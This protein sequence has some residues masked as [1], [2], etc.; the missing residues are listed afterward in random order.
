MRACDTVLGC[1]RYMFVLGHALH[2]LAA[3][4]TYRLQGYATPESYWTCIADPFITNA[5]VRTLG[6]DGAARAS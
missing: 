6:W 3:D 5:K 1:Y 2:M 4:S